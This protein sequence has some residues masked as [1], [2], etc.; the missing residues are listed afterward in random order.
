MPRGN[1]SNLVQNKNQTPEERQKNAKKAGIVSGEK[2]REKRQLQNS[3]QRLLSGRYD[4]KDDKGENTGERMVG[5]DA[6]AK[7]MIRE[8]LDGNVKAFVAIRDT[9]GEKPKESIGI[10][11]KFVNKSN[12]EKRKPEEDPKIIGDY[13]PAT[14]IDDEE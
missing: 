10:S 5:Y 7:S 14:N 1:L 12:R 6:I 4:L 9:I 2:R 13:T 11:I 3:L 8:A